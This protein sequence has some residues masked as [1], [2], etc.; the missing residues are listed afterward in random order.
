MSLEKS[1]SF[2][3]SCAEL[4]FNLLFARCS[5]RCKEPEI[6]PSHSLS[7]R[8]TLGPVASFR[9]R[10]ISAWMSTGGHFDG[11]SGTNLRLVPCT[12]TADCVYL[13]AR[14]VFVQVQEVC[15]DAL[16]QSATESRKWK[17]GPQ[18]GHGTRV[19][20]TNSCCLSNVFLCCLPCLYSV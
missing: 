2:F 11:S 17:N 6:C 13:P 14:S 18:L 3:L 1:W 15:C 4:G 9:M 19:L 12:T 16:F 7:F 10:T 20:I 8:N 5:R